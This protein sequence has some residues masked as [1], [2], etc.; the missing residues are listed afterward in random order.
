MT[1]T[2]QIVA[3]Y[4]VIAVVVIL[5]RLFANSFVSRVAFSWMGP[6]PKDGETWATYQWRWAVYSFDWLIQI[7]VLFGVVNGVLVLFPQTQDHQLLFAFYFG[8]AL[9]L[10]TAF[11]AFLAFLCKAAKAH[12]LGPN[13]TYAL[14]PPLEGHIDV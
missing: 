5:L 6:V 10:G 4:A 7:L 2:A 12:L 3:F 8:L 9:G 13:P 1:T 14:P 11:V